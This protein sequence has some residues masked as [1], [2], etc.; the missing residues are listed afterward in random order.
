METAWA[1]MFQCGL[2]GGEMACPPEL[3]GK[4]VVCPH[5]QGQV[6][7]EGPPLAQQGKNHSEQPPVISPPPA[8][9]VSTHRGAEGSADHSKTLSIGLIILR[10]IVFLPLAYLGAAVASVLVGLVWDTV[11]HVLGQ[12][13]YASVMASGLAFGASLVGIAQGIAPSHKLHVA[14]FVACSL[15]VLS[16]VCL[17]LGLA[18][19][20]DLL[21][22]KYICWN[23]GAIMVARG[24]W[25]DRKETKNALGPS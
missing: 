9:N 8:T 4:V 2:C 1:K 19:I 11:E 15:F 16:V 20:D 13:P 17:C 24:G 3:L 5:C 12:E 22:L 6:V 14:V 10:W 21:I 18:P 7:M 23:A 25:G